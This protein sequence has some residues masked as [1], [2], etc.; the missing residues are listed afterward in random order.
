MSDNFHLQVKA[1]VDA[2]EEQMLA[3]ARNSIQAVV[4]DA[5]LEGPSKKNPAG[6]GGRMRVDTG[7]LRS[8]GVAALNAVPRGP[9]RGEK[10]KTYTWDGQALLTVLMKMKL[11]DT[12][13]FGWTAH[14]A[15][16]REVFDGFVIGATGKWQQI[17]DEQ[18]R[19]FKK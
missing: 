15:R 16:Y 10:D 4:E 12:F 9:T 11:G 3:V 17:V 2:T 6:K 13:Y 7:F 1:W 8:S 18:V 19:R 5:Q 14:Y